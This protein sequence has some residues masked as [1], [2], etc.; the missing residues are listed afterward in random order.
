MHSGRSC[1]FWHRHTSF[2]AAFFADSARCFVVGSYSTKTTSVQILSLQIHAQELAKEP[3]QLQSPFPDQYQDPYGA[4]LIYNTGGMQTMCGHRSKYMT[5]RY[6]HQPDLV[7]L[8][9]LCDLN[10]WNDRRINPPLKLLYTSTCRADFFKHQIALVRTHIHLQINHRI[11]K[12]P[13]SALLPRCYFKL[14]LQLLSSER[15]PFFILPISLSSGASVFIGVYLRKPTSKEGSRLNLDKGKPK[16]GTGRKQR[17]RFL[18]GNGHRGS[19]KFYLHEG[20]DLV[21]SSQEMTHG[22]VSVGEVLAGCFADSG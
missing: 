9:R 17:K 12:P 5:L 22:G 6:D 15:S 1:R 4:R 2:Y 20:F 10:L 14:T 21:V 18:S 16:R 11:W 8:H 19:T 13:L 3:G 7:R